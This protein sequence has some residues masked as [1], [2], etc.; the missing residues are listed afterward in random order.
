MMRSASKTVLQRR[1]FARRTGAV[2]WAQRTKETAELDSALS[3]TGAEDDP[4]LQ[5]ARLLSSI[6]A[7]VAE[8]AK[9]ALR[10]KM[11]NDVGRFDRPTTA[12]ASAVDVGSGGEEDSSADE[13]DN[14]AGNHVQAAAP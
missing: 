13:D 5:K 6:N 11:F 8:V 14:D 2:Y 3:R 9:V 12:A 1:G 4:E 7:S 10:S